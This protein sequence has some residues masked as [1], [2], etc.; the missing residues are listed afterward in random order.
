MIHCFST[1]KSWMRILYGQLK[2]LKNQNGIKQTLLTPTQAVNA[3][4]L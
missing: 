2:R 4:E 1:I 3:V